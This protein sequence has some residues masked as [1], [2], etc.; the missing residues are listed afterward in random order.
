MNVAEATRQYQAT[1]EA[2]RAAWDAANA[3]EVETMD[4]ELAD[5]RQVMEVAW[6]NETAR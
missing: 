5:A 6:L 1:L 2:R 3:D 4:D